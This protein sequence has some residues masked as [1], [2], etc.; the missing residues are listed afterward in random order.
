MEK[1]RNSKFIIKISFKIRAN[2]SIYQSNRKFKSANTAIKLPFNNFWIYLKSSTL[3]V[4]IVGLETRQYTTAST[5]T[6]TESRDRTCQLLAIIDE[7]HFAEGDVFGSTY[8]LFLG[9]NILIYYRISIRNIVSQSS[10]MIL[11]F[12]ERNYIHKCISYISIDF[13]YGMPD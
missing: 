12:K 7:E 6:V 3:F 5:V 13:P 10:I 4:A 9:C 11:D 2:T 1:Y 8:E